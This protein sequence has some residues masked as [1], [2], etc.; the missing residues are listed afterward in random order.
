M[1]SASQSKVVHQ[2]WRYFGCVRGGGRW[3]SSSR[4]SSVRWSTQ[5]YRKFGGKWHGNQY[6]LNV[7]FKRLSSKKPFGS[8][9]WQ[10]VTMHFQNNRT[11]RFYLVVDSGTRIMPSSLQNCSKIGRWHL[12]SRWFT[13]RSMLFATKGRHI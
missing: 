4:V 6:G 10:N 2:P 3:H 8:S 12:H 11:N 1:F 5:K 9:K 7:R 13:G